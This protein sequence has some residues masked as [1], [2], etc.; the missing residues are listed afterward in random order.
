MARLAAERRQVEEAQAVQAHEK[1]VYQEQLEEAE[2]T[3][4][5]RLVATRHEMDQK[6]LADKAAKIVEREEETVKAIESAIKHD[7]EMVKVEGLR[8]EREDVLLGA[9]T[10]ISAFQCSILGVFL[11]RLLRSEEDGVCRASRKKAEEVSG[12]E[13]C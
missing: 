11:R 3:R 6:R 12:R 5:K 1:V 8:K 13:G 9:S 2:V 10:R 4:Q 7:E